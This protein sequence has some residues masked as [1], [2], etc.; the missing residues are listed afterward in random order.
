MDVCEACHDNGWLHAS[1]DGVHEIQR[2]DSCEMIVDDAAA[3]RIHDATCYYGGSKCDWVLNPAPSQNAPGC[4]DLPV[5]A[6]SEFK[7]PEFCPVCNE[8][9]HD[10]N[11]LR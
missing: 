3:T 1:N 4:Y 7:R 8:K 6:S 10:F 5:T 2:C 9:F 11:C